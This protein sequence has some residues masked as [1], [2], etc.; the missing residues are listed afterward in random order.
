METILKPNWLVETRLQ[1][2][3]STDFP[4]LLIAGSP[5]CLFYNEMRVENC[6]I[7]FQNWSVAVCCI[8]VRLGTREKLLYTWVAYP[9]S[10]HTCN[11]HARM[12]VLP[13]GHISTKSSNRQPRT[14]SPGFNKIQKQSA[15]RRL[16]FTIQFSPYS[17]HQILYEKQKYL[18]RAL[19]RANVSQPFFAVPRYCDQWHVAIPPAG[20][21]PAPQASCCTTLQQVCTSG[22]PDVILQMWFFNLPKDL[23]S[24]MAIYIYLYGWNNAASQKLLIPRTRT[25]QAV[26]DMMLSW[27]LH[28]HL[29]NANVKRMSEPSRHYARTCRCTPTATSVTRSKAVLTSRP[30]HFFSAAGAKTKKPELFCFTEAQRQ[31]KGAK[32]TCHRLITQGLHCCFGSTRTIGTLGYQL[33]TL[34]LAPH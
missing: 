34:V 32:I 10:L 15:Q 1:L 33:Q 30:Q 13:L 27:P 4:D 12:D 17:F 24:K 21:S 16:V 26:S 28:S 23:R 20:L 19:M 31:K 6:R 2:H 25:T 9:R 22:S 14:T 18:H 5:T 7:S 3:C 29:K 8:N 11:L